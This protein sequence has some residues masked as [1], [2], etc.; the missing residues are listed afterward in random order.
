[1]GE[2]GISETVRFE[3]DGR[4]HY[5]TVVTMPD[6]ELRFFTYR[7]TDAYLFL[8]HAFGCAWEYVSG[9]IIAAPVTFVVRSIDHAPVVATLAYGRVSAVDTY[10][11]VLIQPARDQR[12]AA[13]VVTAW[14]NLWKRCRRVPSV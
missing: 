7:L 12:D 6:G 11:S 1:M 14:L 2:D 4:E 5:A 10:G 13:D 9:V 3:L 8:N